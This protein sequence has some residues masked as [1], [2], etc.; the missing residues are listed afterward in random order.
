VYDSE[1]ETYQ[2]FCRCMSGFTD[3]FYQKQTAFF[4]ERIIDNPTVRGESCSVWF[5]PCQVWEIRGAELTVSP[6]HKAGEGLLAHESKGLS[7]RFPRFI[8]VREDKDVVDTTSPEQLVDMF[9][10]QHRKLS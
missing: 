10:A 8:R 2:T 4:K 9:H 3:E 5:E 7:C 1:T 6:V